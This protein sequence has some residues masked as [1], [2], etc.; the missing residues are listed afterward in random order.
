MK[1]LLVFVFSMLTVGVLY[2]DTL[3]LAD[4]RVLEGDFVG[5]SNGII[6]FDTGEGI[7]AEFIPR[8]TERFFRV[9]RGRSRDEGGTG[10]GLAIVK[11]VLLR[12]DAELVIESEAGEG[13][14]FCCRFPAQRLVLAEPAVLS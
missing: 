12:H 2:A 3:E 10:L 8:L 5:S 1:R 13:S 11:H 9:D 14:E 7:D 4:G 6:M